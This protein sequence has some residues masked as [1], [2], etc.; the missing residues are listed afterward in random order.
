MSDKCMYVSY[1]T[2]YAFFPIHIAHMD[3]LENEGRTLS[4]VV[5]DRVWGKHVTPDV[6]ILRE[7]V[8]VGYQ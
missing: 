5:C 4:G 3:A 8:A 1:P 2:E 7:V 6:R